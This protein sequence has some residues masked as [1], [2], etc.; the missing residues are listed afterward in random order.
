MLF[1]NLFKKSL[2]DCDITVS[3]K[4]SLP[5]CGVLATTE[6]WNFQSRINCLLLGRFYPTQNNFQIALRLKQARDVKIFLNSG[7]D[8]NQQSHLCH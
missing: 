6:G 4:F 2:V 8:I 1:W 3:E 7:I 5:N